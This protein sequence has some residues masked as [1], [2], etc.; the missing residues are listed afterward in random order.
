MRISLLATFIVLVFFIS[1]LNGC[2]RN[3]CNP[4]GCPRGSEVSPDGCGC[5]SDT[6]KDGR[7][8]LCTYPLSEDI[9]T[10][11]CV[12]THTSSE[13]EIPLRINPNT[14]R[15]YSLSN[16]D[17]LDGKVRIEVTTRNKPYIGEFENY[18]F[19]SDTLADWRCGFTNYSLF[20][21]QNIIV[22]GGTFTPRISIETIYLL[23]ASRE[24]IKNGVL[25][26][27]GAR[28]DLSVDHIKELEKNYQSLEDNGLTVLR[29]KK[30]TCEKNCAKSGNFCEGGFKINS[31]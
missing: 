27:N 9:L 20:A 7:I 22:L 24:A 1:I 15:N 14:G 25:D 4:A 16:F 13:D 23:G 28:Y 21:T 10:I 2:A 11:T 5:C 31:S 12:D 26:L 8:D 3:E 18:C 19:D 17:K 6:D 30:V 29:L